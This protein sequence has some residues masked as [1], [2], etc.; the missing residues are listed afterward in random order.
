MA[1][2]SI[3]LLGHPPGSQIEVTEHEELE[4]TC[5]VGQAKPKAE[6]RWYKDEIR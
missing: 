3:S 6:I 1:P 5:E 2:T 4:I